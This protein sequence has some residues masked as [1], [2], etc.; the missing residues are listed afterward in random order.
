MKYFF[1][2]IP[3]QYI[4]LNKNQYKENPISTKEIGLKLLF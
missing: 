4:S 3:I 1:Y 2:F